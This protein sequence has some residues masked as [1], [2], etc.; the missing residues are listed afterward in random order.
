MEWLDVTAT[1]KKNELIITMKD[2]EE[3]SAQWWFQQARAITHVQLKIKALITE[4][5]G[6]TLIEVLFIKWCWSLWENVV[7][8]KWWNRLQEVRRWRAE[9]SEENSTEKCIQV[10][11]VFIICLDTI[12]STSWET[13][14][15]SVKMLLLEWLLFCSPS[16][17][18]KWFFFRSA[19]EW[20]G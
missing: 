1:N 13:V 19:T 8:I 15:I 11:L 2:A 17:I 16:Y 9:K 12:R 4:W 10:R 14:F 20:C 6:G 5:R 18:H 7:I 3:Q